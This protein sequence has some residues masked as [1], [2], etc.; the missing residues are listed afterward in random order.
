MNSATN[1]NGVSLPVVFMDFNGMFGQAQGG[2]PA[3]TQLVQGN[4][5]VT[6]LDSGGQTSTRGLLRAI[7]GIGGPALGGGMG[8]GGWGPSYGAD[9]QGK[10]SARRLP[11]WPW[12]D[13]NIKVIYTAGYNPI[14]PDL[15]VACESL[16]SF[17][18]RT[19]PY[20]PFFLTNES[21]GDY[22]YGLSQ[23]QMGQHP[24]IGT[25]RSLLAQ[26]RDMTW[27]GTG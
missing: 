26:Y 5:F 7:A 6:R 20:G 17:M 15:S 4:Q 25:I 27:G 21:L 9:Y 11:C 10:L 8:G 24:E 12:G 18:V 1:Y 3:G 13:G 2:F 23:L 22:S 14:P 16:V 19:L